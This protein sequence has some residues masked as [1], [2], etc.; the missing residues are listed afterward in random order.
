M[1]AQAELIGAGRPVPVL[2]SI[3]PLASPIASAAF[4]TKFINT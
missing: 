2:I 1:D 4:V 3:V